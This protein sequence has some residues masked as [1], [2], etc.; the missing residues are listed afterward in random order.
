MKRIKNPSQIIQSGLEASEILP[1]PVYPEAS[2]C[3]SLLNR[4]KIPRK[5][6][7]ALSN[8]VRLSDAEIHYLKNK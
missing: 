5:Q 7:Y 6:T 8:Y 3:V 1:P 2:S 4:K